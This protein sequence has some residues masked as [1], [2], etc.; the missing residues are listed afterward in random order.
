VT[1][2]TIC[3]IYLQEKNINQQASPGR[4]LRAEVVF[5]KPGARMF[6]S[7]SSLSGRAKHEKQFA[8]LFPLTSLPSSRLRSQRITRQLAYLL[9]ADRIQPSAPE[10]LL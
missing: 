8:I 4:L 2:F 5:C 1:N 3:S 10:R 6:S 7:S 9:N